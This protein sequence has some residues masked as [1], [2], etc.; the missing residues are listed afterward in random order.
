AE[1]LE[2]GFSARYLMDI[3]DQMES[4]KAIFMLADPSSPTLIRD[5]EDESALYVLMPMRV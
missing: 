5:S 3:V 2:I 1:T 4:E